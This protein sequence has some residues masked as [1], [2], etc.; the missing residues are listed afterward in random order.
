MSSEPAYSSRKRK[1]DET[2]TLLQLC[3]NQEW[4]AAMERSVSHP[5]EALEQQRNGT[6]PLALACREGA[7]AE[8]VKTLLEASPEPV[9]NLI[10]S[11]GTPLH[12][13]IVCE[14][15]VVSVQSNIVELLLQA[16]EKL[17]GTSACLLQDVD[18]HTP[19]H[20]LIRRR[21]QLHLESEDGGWFHM[22]QLLV[23]RAPEAVGIPDRSEYE[24]PPLVMALKANTY[25]GHEGNG[26]MFQRIE[27]RI[28]ETVACMLEHYPQAARNTL[29]GARGHYTPLHSAVFHG[30]CP[31]TIHLLLNAEQQG[32]A[33]SRAALLAN[34]QGELPLHFAAMRG[35]PPRSI[36]LLANAAP[37][38]VLTRD[39]TGLTPFH[40]LW[41]RFVST[42]LALENER[43]ETTVEAVR[44]TSTP[45][46]KYLD[47]ASLERGDFYADLNMIRK[48][49]PP[50][51]FLQMRHTSPELL[52]EGSNA[53]QWANRSAQ[54]LSSTRQRYKDEEDQRN[55][56][57]TRR[58]AVTG[59][60]WTKVVSLLKAAASTMNANCTFQL[61]HTALSCPS[62]PPPVAQLI[63]SLFPEELAMRDP[64]T[65]K[66]PLHL[67][68]SRSWHTWDWPRPDAEAEQTRTSEPAAAQLLRG[69]SIAV[70]QTAI[71][72]SPP[73]AARVAD[74]EGRLALHHAIDSFVRACSNSGRSY[75]VDAHTP[76][77]DNMLQV[78][79]K[80]VQS[81]PESLER[82][83]GKTKLYP[84]LQATA[85][86][87]EYRS[88]PSPNG[89]NVPFPDEMPLSMVYALLRENPSLVGK[90]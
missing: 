86:A 37:M 78:L 5:E 74:G 14:R 60:F 33:S 30:R 40:W 13:A 45:D 27:R 71:E 46:N 63:C 41:I 62:C 79:G 17:P 12:E 85:A 73:Q 21:F 34:T 36:A 10:Q 26:I 53:S 55:T 44:I 7:P 70:L 50:V 32:C 24:E 52:G 58:E 31:D 59:L 83:D 57:W 87:T 47:F 1:L 84:F 61:V 82:R 81:H 56:V 80:L 4:Q 89:F 39:V 54:V 72:A 15:N 66:L 69:E 38:A 65:G 75:M 88:P 2:L 11:R 22:L 64:S 6:T 48:L 25:V 42:L 23:K 76:P 3:A 43:G 8:C 9:R 77:V 90:S 16:D 29:T 51:D 49:D 20:S 67:A 35:E 18:G 19:L 68:A 28:R